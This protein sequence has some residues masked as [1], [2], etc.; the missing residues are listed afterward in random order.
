MTIDRVKEWNEFAKQV[1]DYISE[2][3]VSKYGMGE[4]TK[5]KVDFD[6]MTFTEPRICVWNILKYAF[7]LFNN[8]GKRHDLFKIVHYAQMA[9]TLSSGD[10]NKAGI[11]DVV[12]APE[13]E[14]VP[15]A[16]R[17]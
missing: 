2:F 1:S 3:T 15:Q 5:N 17:K 12:I 11:R 9:Y 4:N 7:R 6:L 14:E 10:L 8:M 13:I 16:D